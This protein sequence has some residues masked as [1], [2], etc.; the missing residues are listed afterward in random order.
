MSQHMIQTWYEVMAVKFSKVMDVEVPLLSKLSL[1]IL[2]W[3]QSWLTLCKTYDAWGGTGAGF[4]SSFSSFPLLIIIPPLLHTHLSSFPELC[5]SP[6]HTTHYYIFGLYE[7]NFICDWLQSKEINFLVS[8]QAHGIETWNVSS[9]TY[10]LALQS[11]K[12]LDLLYNRSSFCS[13]IYL[14]SLSLCFQLP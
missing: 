7:G 9:L 3:I 11:T 2:F 10:F 12:K 1:G 8:L 5:G 14:F 13:L 4:Y 6:D